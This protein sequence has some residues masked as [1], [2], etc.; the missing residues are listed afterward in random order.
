[1]KVRNKS[2]NINYIDY[3]ETAIDQIEQ[4][5]DSITYSSYPE[6]N[7]RL[8]AKLKEAINIL[9]ACSEAAIFKP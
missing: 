3:L 1:M 5:I 2:E 6:M 9:D 7:Q 8:A 4:V